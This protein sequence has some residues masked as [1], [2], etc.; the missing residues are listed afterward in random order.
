LNVGCE[1]SIQ[2]DI[3]GFGNATDEYFLNL[4]LFEIDIDRVFDI[5]EVCQIQLVT[6]EHNFFLL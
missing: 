3:I 1:E 2:I 5:N 6:G 4:Y